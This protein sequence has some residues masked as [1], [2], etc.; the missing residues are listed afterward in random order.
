MGARTRPAQPL[1]AQSGDQAKY[2]AASK[3]RVQF[4]SDGTTST[5]SPSGCSPPIARPEAAKH[6]VRRRPNRSSRKRTS[7]TMRASQR[8]LVPGTGANHVPANG[9]RRAAPLPGAASA[10][11]P[12]YPLGPF[13]DLDDVPVGVV[14]GEDRPPVVGG[15]ARGAQVSRRGGDRVGRVVDVAVA[16]AVGGS[17]ARGNRTRACR[18]PTR[19]CRRRAALAG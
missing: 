2:R 13:E 4:P 15:G 6:A 9:T 12:R 18:A 11:A 17:R 7:G 14:V 10:S 3:V 19:F 16:V 1:E 8:R 5:A